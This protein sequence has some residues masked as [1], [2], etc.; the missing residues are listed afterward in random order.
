MNIELNKRELLSEIE[1]FITDSDLI[2]NSKKKSFL[3]IC[4]YSSK[5]FL[6]TCLAI[7][8]F[9]IN[10]SLLIF[11]IL[12]LLVA[13]RHLQTHV[14]DTAHYFIS[15]NKRMNDLFGNY[16][17]AGFIGMTIENYRSIHQKH[18]KFN[19]SNEDPEYFSYE[20]VRN[21]GGLISL[22]LK[23]SLGFEAFKLIKKYYFSNKYSTTNPKTSKKLF[24]VIFSQILLIFFF[25]INGLYFFYIIWLY[26]AMTISPLLSRLRFLV[27]HPGKNNTTRTTSSTFLEKIFFA[28]HNFNYHFEHHMWPMIPPY[29]LARIHNHLEKNNFFKIN[30]KYISNYFISDLIKNN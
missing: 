21:H 23:Y 5:T 30:K 28:P 18:H 9:K 1:G 19:G 29:N 16:L 15:D 26:L 22:C 3:K 11:S 17:Y 14:H 2:N 7:L 20:D 12:M 8:L 10:S 27:E 6:W 25:G 13:Q 4:L 24:H